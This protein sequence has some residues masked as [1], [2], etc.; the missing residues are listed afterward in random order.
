MFQTVLKQNKSQV[1]HT[2]SC[3]KTTKGSLQNT[4]G[5]ASIAPENPECYL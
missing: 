2:L 5:H 1:S 4:V 3:H